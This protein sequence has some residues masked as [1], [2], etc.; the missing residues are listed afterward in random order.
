[1]YNRLVIKVFLH[2]QD[3]GRD[4]KV[5]NSCF[6]KAFTGKKEI[7]TYTY[8]FIGSTIVFWIFVFWKEEKFI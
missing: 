5:C 4:I 7:P 2:F 1:M 3:N 8:F 6:N